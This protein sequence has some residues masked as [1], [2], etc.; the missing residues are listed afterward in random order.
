MSQLFITATGTEIG[1]THVTALLTTAFR[2]AAR[3]VCALKPIATGFDADAIAASDS[4]R[5]LA[6]QGM[7]VSTENLE[8]VT[9]WRFAQ[10]LS[11]DMAAARERRRIPFGELLAFCRAPRAADMTLIEGIGG[12]MTPLDDTHTVL[13]WVE[14]FAA[15]TLLVAGSYLG[16]L[17]HTLTAVG[18]LRRHNPTLLYGVVVSESPEQPVD[19][20]ETARVLARFCAPAPVVVLPR[21]DSP[22]QSESALL[23]LVAPLLE[24]GA[25]A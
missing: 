7:T 25:R 11:P 23:E 13:D 24:A 3:S 4:G 12:L 18:M 19:A 9:P 21:K 8:Q 20:A 17:S 16:T 10:P 6:A 15:P 22:V 1:K 2:A 5:L 14:A